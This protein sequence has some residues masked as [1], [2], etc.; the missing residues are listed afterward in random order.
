MEELYIQQFGKKRI[1]LV[2]G[3]NG[4][5]AIV[6][7]ISTGLIYAISWNIFFNCHTKLEPFKCNL[8]EYEGPNL[9][10]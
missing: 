9:S 3:W 4:D 2:S 10:T 7:D 6:E 5:D 8:D 1:V